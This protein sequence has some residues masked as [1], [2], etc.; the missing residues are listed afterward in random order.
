MNLQ[1]PDFLLRCHLSAVV[2]DEKPLA[3]GHVHG[4]GFTQAH[5]GEREKRVS[6]SDSSVA[7]SKMITDTRKAQNTTRN[8]SGTRKLGHYTFSSALTGL[9]SVCEAAKCLR[10]VEEIL[11]LACAYVRVR[12]IFDIKK[13][14]FDNM[15]GNYSLHVKSRIMVRATVTI[16]AWTS[17]NNN[18]K[19]WGHE[20]PAVLQDCRDVHRGPIRDY[21]NAESL[22]KIPRPPGNIRPIQVESFCI[23]SAYACICHI[24]AVA[25]SGSQPQRINPVAVDSCNLTYPPDSARISRSSYLLTF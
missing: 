9:K 11:C 20:N 7:K 12:A 24:F 13:W 6:E 17:C 4:H 10:N 23:L 1:N 3:G 19:T 16:P 18:N 15:K 8:K 2:P 5:S 25:L 22:S 14:R 21:E